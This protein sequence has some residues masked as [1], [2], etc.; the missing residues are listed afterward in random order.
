[1][2][3]K[4]YEF[5]LDWRDYVFP[6]SESQFATPD[7]LKE[8]FDSIDLQDNEPNS[9]GIPL[10]VSDNKAI[11]NNFT[12]NTIVYGETGSKKTRCCIKPLL[13]SLI[14]S[15]ESTI[16][17]DPK[18]EL[19]S[20]PT[21]RGLLKEH[22]YFTY[23]LDFRNFKADSYN[24]LE[25]AFK[26]Y[27]NG[28]EDRAM[29][30]V[31]RIIHSLGRKY[32]GTKADP[33]WSST[34]EQILIP[35]IHILM[36]VFRDEADG[37]QNINMM[38][39]SSYINEEGLETLGQIIERHCDGINNSSLAMLRGALSGS[40]K[41]T[42]NISASTSTFLQPFLIQ[43]AMT[44]MLSNSSF[45]IEGMYDWPTVLFIITP[46]ETSTYDAIC[47]MLIDNIY[48]RLID[49]YTRKYQNRCQPGCRVNFVCDEFC[50]LKIND[51][52]PKI[53][54]CRSREIR[55]FLVCQSMK[56]LESTY[57]DAAI[58]EGNCKNI[59]FMQSS[60]I[61]LLQYI[62]ALCGTTNITE[63]GEPEPLVSLGMLKNL[64]KEQDFKEILFIRDNIIYRGKFPDC[65]TYQCIQK[66]H[67]SQPCDI[68][69]RTTNGIQVFSPDLLW[70]ALNNFHLRKPF[71]SQTHD[72][73]SNKKDNK[74]YTSLDVEKSLSTLRQELKELQK[75]LTD[76]CSYFD[77][78]EAE[79]EE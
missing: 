15:E 77:D 30:N 25:H 5:E 24:I 10:F 53:S 61:S 41:T 9:S 48:A 13:Y 32:E 75:D 73:I 42:A 14:R 44:E 19:A 21:I 68:P 47:G 4:L 46:D 51:M 50:N 60:D 8:T 65:D 58:I 55:F 35:L 59:I 33:F 27:Q 62:S 76:L 70:S 56:Q 12:E 63:S 6:K 39:L 71:S 79:A 37:K 57:P 36:D 23:F 1:M 17:T 31:A 3:K 34:S 64:K 38:T 20:D 52:G 2:K 7:E 45:Q 74:S 29:E 66:Y 18:G 40:E 49:V 16:I 67:S 43:P 69:T 22:G 28:D 54:A 72:T 26:L 78:D 11:V